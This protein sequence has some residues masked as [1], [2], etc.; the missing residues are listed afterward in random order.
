MTLIAEPKS[1]LSSLVFDRVCTAAIIVKHNVQCQIVGYVE[2]KGQ[3]VVVK[4]L[5]RAYLCEEIN[6]DKA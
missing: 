3:V 4:R 2:N 5:G 6:D 1:T